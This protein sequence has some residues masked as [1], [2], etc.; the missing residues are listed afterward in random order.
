[1]IPTIH[2]PSATLYNVIRAGGLALA[3]TNTGY[4]LV[5]MSS[6]AVRRIYELKGRPCEKPCVAVGTLAIFDDVTQG[7]G[8]GTRRWL[9]RAVAAWP[10]AIIARMNPRS[11]LVRSLDPF[12][13]SQCTKGNTMATFFGVGDRIAGAASIAHRENRLV[14][15]SSANLAGTGNHYS[16]DS[17]P[18]SIRRGVDLEIDDGIAPFVS[19]KKLASTIL[20]LTT[21]T[22]HRE[23]ACFAELEASWRVFCGSARAA[24]K[25]LLRAA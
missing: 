25:S 9:E 15:G 17:V 5:G 20:D 22:F 12:V 10:V 7:V 18:D 21:N 14:V 1:M 24:G 13:A 23:G 2:D 4:G 3:R 16:L 8:P 19:D 6:E 11:S